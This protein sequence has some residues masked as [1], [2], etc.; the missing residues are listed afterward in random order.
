[1]AKS[2]MGVM[3]LVSLVSAANTFWLWSSPEELP[4]VD[5]DLAVAE[6]PAALVDDEVIILNNTVKQTSPPMIVKPS[7]ET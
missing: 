3:V 6:G 5:E 7:T 1:M 4:A 2:L